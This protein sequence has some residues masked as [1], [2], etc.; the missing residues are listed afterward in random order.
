MYTESDIENN[1]D[2]IW[3]KIEITGNMDLLWRV[4]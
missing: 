1:R 3:L 2:E 4:V